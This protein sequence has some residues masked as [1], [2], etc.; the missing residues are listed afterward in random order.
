MD[1]Q[2]GRR[3]TG[4]T[5]IELLVV[6][7]I[8]AILAAIL[9]PVF[10]QA[11][12]KARQIAC[13]SN[14]K[15]LGLAFLQY[16]QDYDETLPLANY[17]NTPPATGNGSWNFEIDPYIKG[18]VDP[19]QNNNGTAH[20]SVYTCPDF[21]GTDATGVTSTQF[22]TLPQ[23][24]GLPFK[25]YVTNLNITGS[26]A[27]TT[28]PTDPFF[29]PSAVLAQ[30]RS[31]ANLVL[32]AEGRGNVLYT[33]GND[34]SSDLD[35]TQFP[36]ENYHDWGNYVAARGRHSGGSNYLLADGHVKFFRAPSPN[37]QAGGNNS[38]PNVSQSGVVYSQAQYPNA[39]AWFL[40]NPNSP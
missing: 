31:P 18:G 16:A 35:T 19:T 30:L 4:F 1:M 15:Q 34:T 12:E 6:I 24:T 36:I 11:R 29:R 13:V 23:P 26:L 40:E 5:L 10:A 7:A 21:S 3:H 37:Y 2:V 14:E 27:A 28:P 20:K 17:V 8:I 9:F 25:S 39:A 32:L 22:P 38:V 33:T